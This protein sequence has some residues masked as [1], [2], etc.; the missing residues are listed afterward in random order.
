MPK[1]M[2][3][4]PRMARAMTRTSGVPEWASCSEKKI[5]TFTQG[6]T[7]TQ[8]LPFN[9]LFNSYNFN[10]SSTTRARSVAQA[11][12]YFRIKRVTFRFKPETDTFVVGTPVPMLYYQIDKTLSCSQF[13]AISQ[14]RA[15][16]CRGT[17]FNREIT[18]SFKPAVAQG[19]VDNQPNYGTQIVA[20][21]LLSPWIS[22][23]QQAGNPLVSTWAPSQADH[24]GLIWGVESITAQAAATTFYKV[25]VEYEYEFKKPLINSVPSSEEQLP[26]YVVGDDELGNGKEQTYIKEAPEL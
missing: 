10:L 17:P 9:T 5:L 2:A 7:T 4:K 11:Y 8:S 22:T 24:M 18:V 23:N 15:I 14:F 25:E 6:S 1:R 26:V 21:P 19:V 13:T 12:Q 20:K 3:R 16:G